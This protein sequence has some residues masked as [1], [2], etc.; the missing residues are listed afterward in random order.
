MINPCIYITIN[1]IPDLAIK[2]S[3]KMTQWPCLPSTRFQ[4]TE[5]KQIKF[6]S[7]SCQQHQT[8]HVITNHSY[9]T[10]SSYIQVILGHTIQD[11]VQQ[12]G[13]DYKEGL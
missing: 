10:F 1:E 2:I 8:W 3:T 9:S 12:F 4:I 7:I 5:E 6:I 11:R 13:H